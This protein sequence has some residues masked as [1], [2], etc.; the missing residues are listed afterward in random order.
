MLK[1]SSIDLGCGTPLDAGEFC[2]SLDGNGKCSQE[3]NWS[4]QLSIKFPCSKI[5]LEI[6][7]NVNQKSPQ[8]LRY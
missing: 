7:F 3:Y 8:M 4:L 6:E 2:L 5:P 1:K